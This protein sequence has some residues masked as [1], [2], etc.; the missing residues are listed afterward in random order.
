MYSYEAELVLRSYLP[1]ELEKG[2]LFANLINGVI[3]L[4]ELQNIP[5][6]KDKF[7]VEHGAP[8]ELYI[9]DQNGSIIAEPNE[10]GWFDEGEDCDELR[11]VSLE[12]I[13]TIVR[14]YNGW[15]EIEIYEDFYDEDGSIIPNFAGQKVIIKFL[16]EDE[17]E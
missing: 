11:D 12:D 13:N 6:N 7:M 5:E 8:M 16:T 17:E 9:I 1:E 3:I 4:W 2:M 14:D 15:L 10:I